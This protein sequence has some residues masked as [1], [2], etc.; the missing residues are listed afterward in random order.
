MRASIRTTCVAGALAAALAAS[1]CSSSSSNTPPA[2][3]PAAPAQLVVSAQANQVLLQWTPVAGATTYS[4]YYA[5]SPGVKHGT[6]TAITGVRTPPRAVAGL[7][8]GTAY[9]FVVTA[10]GP[11]GESVES[12][13][14]SATPY[15]P[16]ITPAAPSG[17]RAAPGDGQVTVSWLPATGASSYALYWSTAPGVSKTAT[18]VAS[19]VSPQ[20][21]TG[22]TNGTTS[23]FAV[24]GID[25]VGEGSL[26]LEVSATPS[27]TPP[28]PAPT[29]VAA[30][31]GDGRVT[32]SWSPVTGATS[33][34]VYYG[35]ASGVSKTTGTK[36]AAA[37]SPQV[38]T[39]LTNEVGIYAV[40]TATGASGESVESAEVTAVPTAAGVTFSQADL[41]GDWDV[42]QFDTA[43]A[44]GWAAVL[45]GVDAAGKVTLKAFLN[46][47]G[48]TTLPPP[49][50][51]QSLRVAADGTLTLTG[52]DG[53]AS[54]H[55]TLARG[56][57]LA[58]ATTTTNGSTFELVI[59]R[60]R[61]AGVTYSAADVADFPFAYHAVYAG[62][63]TQTGW[64]YGDGTTDASGAVTLAHAYDTSGP[65]EP[66]PTNLGSVVVDA[67][68]LVTLG[69]SSDFH[70]LMT[71]EK[72]AIFWV[73]TT[74]PGSPPELQLMAI[75]KTRG[76]FAQADLTGAYTVH[77]LQ[78]G[79][80]T[81][82]SNWSRGR[83]GIDD[84]GNVAFSSFL[85]SS[86]VTTLPTPFTIQLGADGALT[87]PSGDTTFHGRVSAGNTF[88]VRT[89]GTATSAGLAVGLR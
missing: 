41:T 26:S 68:G 33:Y 60:K 2:N 14:R 52:A 62:M 6:G 77:V 32:V 3:P 35:T 67:N 71:A 18:R 64:E 9:Y 5:T 16:P 74:T 28:P 61:V 78:S 73:A 85:N 83:L 39:G 45:A 46:S 59:L 53:N 86:G 36:L 34:T 84:L 30:T 19:A 55:G 80:N 20:V 11:G 25:P 44:P 79:T 49:G 54:F 21:V 66:L 88:Y 81:L 48:S 23:W 82:T 56:K 13:E 22:L 15:G 27:A 7:T 57:T 40:V 89:A 31:G 51:D 8:N 4:I 17:L 63:P 38:I 65:I 72:D 69:G 43:P 1:G 75:L 37:T 50:F 58:V 10:V 70:G 24:A 42:V 47:S 29:G 12:P 87:R 76:G